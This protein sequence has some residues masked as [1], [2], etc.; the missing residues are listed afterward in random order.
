[1]S[2]RPLRRALR[3]EHMGVEALAQ[4][5][6]DEAKLLRG[7]GADAQAAALESCASE[8]EEEVQRFSLETLTL[9]QAE[10]ES[11]YSYHALQKMLADGR[12]PNAGAR[13][14]PRIRRGDLPKKPS[15]GR[16]GAKGDPDL[17]SLVLAGSD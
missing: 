1:M 16:E 17:A 15:I 13:H 4:Q 8:L 10:G 6:R 14:R 5:W 2:G 3:G 12:L 9:A 7:R 11:G